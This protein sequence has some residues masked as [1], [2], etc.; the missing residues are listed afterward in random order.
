M[1]RLATPD[2]SM[3]KP[4]FAFTECVMTGRNA[5]EVAGLSVGYSYPLFSRI[6]S[7][8]TWGAEGAPEGFQRSG[9]DNASAD[10][11]AAYISTGRELPFYPIGDYWYYAQQEEW[12][13]SMLTPF[14]LV[15]ESFLLCGVQR[16]SGS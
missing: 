3:A 1:S 15:A 8:V 5:L 9:K 13:E 10:P 11:Y 12:S 4:V 16:Y 7:C 2:I 14:E 6:E